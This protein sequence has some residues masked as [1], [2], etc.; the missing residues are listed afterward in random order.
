MLTHA[1]ISLTLMLSPGGLLEDAKAKAAEEM[2]SKVAD[3]APGRSSPAAWCTSEG[4]DLGGSGS[5]IRRQS[6]LL[7]QRWWTLDAFLGKESLG[8]GWAM[9]VLP[10]Q[11]EDQLRLFAGV[12][13]V[14]KMDGEPLSGGKGALGVFVATRW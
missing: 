14:L 11:G 4:C 6:R 5:L 8:V 7:T 12:A 3:A 13:V 1:L 2:A 9:E 10:Y